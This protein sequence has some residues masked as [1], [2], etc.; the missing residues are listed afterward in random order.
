MTRDSPPDARTALAGWEARLARDPLD[1]EALDGAW[2]AATDAGRHAQ[3]LAHLDRALALEPAFPPLHFMRAVSLQ[4][5]ARY[6]EAHAALREALRLRFRDQARP[7]APPPP[8]PRVPVADVTLACVDCRNHELAVF[9]LRRSMAQCRFAR[10][11][12]LTNRALG[13]PDIEVRVIPD[14]GSIADYSR[15]MVKALAEHVDTPHVLVV[16]YD[17]YVLNGGVWDARFADYDYI[18]APWAEPD[19]GRRVGNGGFSLRSR[20]LLRALA[21]PRIQDLVPEDGAICRTYR[22]LLEDEHGIRFAPPELAERFAFESLPPAGPTFGFHGIAHMARIVD[23]TR[24]E[25]AAYRPEGML[26]F[27]KL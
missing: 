11:V 18:G 12:L 5:L 26:L 24:E 7:D 19:G 15:F 6:D 9:A 2:R 4:G 1:G 21:D 17:G 3:A 25:L 14:I 16:Q 20:K 22:R 10:A 13:L 27:S 8:G 23:M